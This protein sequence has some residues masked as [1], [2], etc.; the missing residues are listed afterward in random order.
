V[1]LAWLLPP[2]SQKPTKGLASEAVFL[3][4]NFFRS[5]KLKIPM[6]L[7]LVAF[8]WNCENIYRRTFSEF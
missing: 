4:A 1:C 3:K 7:I 5:A 6:D 2:K 8:R